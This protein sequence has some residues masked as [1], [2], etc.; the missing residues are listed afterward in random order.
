MKRACVSLCVA[1]VVGAGGIA[2]AATPDVVLYATDIASTQGNWTTTASA[3]SPGGQKLTSNDFGWATTDTPRATPSDYVEAVFSA[4]SATP[5]HVWL[6]LRA[7]DN[8]K[9]NDS[10]W[11]QFDDA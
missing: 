2:R 11:V 8:S 10:V 7:I 9:W 4:P 3:S 5:Y 6:R 1:I